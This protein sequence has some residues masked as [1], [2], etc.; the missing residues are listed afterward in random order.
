MPDQ[1][2]AVLGVALNDPKEGEGYWV[3]KVGP[4][5]IAGLPYELYIVG[6]KVYAPFARYRIA[7][8]WPALGMGQFMGISHIPEAIRGTLPSALAAH[9]RPGPLDGE[10]WS[11]LAAN[12]A[13]AAKLRQ[14]QPRLQARLVECG[15]PA[16]AL[17]IKVSSA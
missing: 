11:L 17:R 13:V 12:P 10:G 6:N 2:I 8:A 9:V 16:L 15:W 4:Q 1:K 7:L 3:N 5:H 14:L